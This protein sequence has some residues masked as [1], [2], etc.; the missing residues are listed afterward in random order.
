M[1][2][3]TVGG[4][5]KIKVSFNDW[6]YIPTSYRKIRIGTITQPEMFVTLDFD[7]ASYAVNDQGSAKVKVR[8]PD[9]EKVPA[10]TSIS[11]ELSGVKNEANR[12]PLDRQGEA[13]IY[14]IVPANSR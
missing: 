3:D 8:M 2:K 11:F 7:K 5:Y 1:P 14:F 10:G 4:E 13:M 9:G 6:S 12:I